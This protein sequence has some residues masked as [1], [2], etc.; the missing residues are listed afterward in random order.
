MQ[1]YRPNQEESKRLMDVALGCA[2]AELA[3]IN[4][5]LLN[6]YTGEVL[7]NSQIAVMGNW[8]AYVGRDAS[9]AIGPQTEVIDVAGQTVIPGLIEGHTHLVWFASISEQLRHLIP[10]GTTTVISETLEAFPVA[11]AQGVI[12]VLDSFRDQPIKVFGTAPAMVSISR[13]AE[14]MAPDVLERLMARDDI[15]GMG[16][17]YW[18]ALIHRPEFLLPAYQTALRHHK[19]LEGHS[20]GASEKKLNAY[21]AAG[22]SSCHEPITAEEVIDR[23]RLGMHVMIREGSIRRDLETIAKISQSGIHTR[24]LILS[25]DG[26]TPGDLIAK[27]GLDFV[28]QKAVDCG[29]DP[30]SAVQMATLNVA[31]HFGLDP[32]TGGIAPGRCADMLVIPDLHTIVPQCVISNGRVVAE[33]GRLRAAPRRHAYTPENRRTIGLNKKLGAEDFAIPVETN[34][35]A[36]HVRLIKMV[37]DLVTKEAIVQM[38]VSAGHLQIDV[39]QDILKIA[40]IDRTI[41]PGKRFTGLIR[42]FGLKRGALAA[43]NAWDTSDLMVVG[44]DEADMALAVN[45]I[46]ELQGGAVLCAGGQVLEEIALPVL[47]IIADLSLEDL[48]Q[49]LSAI[50]AAAADLGCTFRDPLLSLVALS[51]AAIPFLRICE[52][53]LVDLKTG[54]TLGLFVESN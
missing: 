10:R 1:N 11:G 21:V 40:A 27:G 37:S 6:V 49:R 3:L 50:T 43:S 24:G 32:I 23:L 2:Q 22:I 13:A 36:C 18:Q 16:E 29:I 26:L 51:G 33:K 41:K 9:A 19:T 38:P 8:I 42:G 46:I 31:E 28:L 45:R 47:G 5:R 35:E 15:L 20:A 30:V 12:D 4:A 7:D 25:T 48:A 17:S 39:N 53:G 52:E 54:R 34:A 14:G 44:A